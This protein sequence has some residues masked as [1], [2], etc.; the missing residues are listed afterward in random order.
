MY[1]LY[2]YIHTH[3][4]FI[5]IYIHTGYI[6]I[7]TSNI[8]FIGTKCHSPPSC[9]KLPPSRRDKVL[10]LREQIQRSK[11]QAVEHRRAEREL[12]LGT[13][14]WVY[15][16]KTRWEKNWQKVYVNHENTESYPGIICLT[17]LVRSHSWVWTLQIAPKVFVCMCWYI[18]YKI[19]HRCT[20]WVE[21]AQTSPN[22]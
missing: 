13:P 1:P 8:E 21:S 20:I 16:Q 17:W 9:S 7:H 15:K 11:Q 19:I 18:V 3:T 4:W 2:V 22:P 6:Y 14:K 12:R 10:T 5:Y